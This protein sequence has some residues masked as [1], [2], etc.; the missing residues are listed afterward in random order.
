MGLFDT[1][2][3]LDQQQEA[4][5]L[6]VAGESVRVETEKEYVMWVKPTE[7]G[8]AWLF[9]QQAQV[10]MDVLMPIARGRRRVRLQSGGKAELTVK[11]MAGEGKIEENSDIGFGAGLSFYEDGHLAHLVRRIHMDAGELKAQGA[12]HWDI[13]L[14]YTVTGHPVL[15]TQ[16]DFDA[17]VADLQTATSFGRWVKVE[18]EVE[19]FEINTIKDVIPFGVAEAIPGGPKDPETQEML[20]HY[21]DNETRI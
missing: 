14:F 1:L 5:V 2:A 6:K 20:R 12:K 16:E 13:D 15:E 19:R 10:Y 8:W 9:E 18:L 17:L 7:E 4:D 3:K 11:R 21:W